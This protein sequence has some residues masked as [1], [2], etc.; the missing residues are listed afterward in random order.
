MKQRDLVNSHCKKRSHPPKVIVG[1]DKGK[2]IVKF[3]PAWDRVRL[4]S[5][6]V[7]MAIL[8]QYLTQLSYCLH[9]Q[10]QT[11]LWIHLSSLKKMY[12]ISFSNYQRL[13]IHADSFIKMTWSN[14]TWN[15][16]ICKEKTVSLVY[17]CWAQWRCY[18]EELYWAEYK[19]MI[20]LPTSL[21]VRHFFFFFQMPFHQ[22]PWLIWGCSCH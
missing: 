7:E 14:G 13:R 16:S 21:I 3:K 6:M 2:P 15:G 4:G 1:V 18:L 12:F 11:D 20:W 10:R 5:G 8:E 22:E 9:L 17:E 19:A